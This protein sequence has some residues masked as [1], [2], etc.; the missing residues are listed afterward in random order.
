MDQH[1]TNGRST[2]DEHITWDDFTKVEIRIGTI[3]DAAPNEKAR[4]P[5]YVLDIDLGPLGRRRSS[6]QITDR[7]APED[8]VGRQVLCVTNFPPLRVA[9]VKS[10]VLVTGFADPEGAVVL[11][12]ADSTV[13]NGSRLI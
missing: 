11:A 8:L 10:E 5:A 1:E 6:A 3:V 9:G 4:R 12:T 13:A 2:A 7:Y